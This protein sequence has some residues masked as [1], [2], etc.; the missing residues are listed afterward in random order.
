MPGDYK[1]KLNRKTIDC[2]DTKFSSMLKRLVRSASPADLPVFHW[3]GDTFDLPA[4]ALHLARTGLYPNQAFALGN[5]ALALQFHPE[6]TECL[7]RW[8]GHACELRQKGIAIAQLRAAAHTHAPALLTAASHFGNFGWTTSCS[9]RG[10]RRSAL[11][12]ATQLLCCRPLR[13][14]SRIQLGAFHHLLGDE[15]R[16]IPPQRQRNRI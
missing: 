1:E 5:Y 8:Y 6:V 14:A 13:R 10:P 7:E 4:G 12:P 2:I 15:D 9:R 3:H 11:Q 16:A